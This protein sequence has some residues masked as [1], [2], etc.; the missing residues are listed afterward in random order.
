MSCLESFVLQYTL[1][2]SI[3]AIGGD[4]GLEDDAEGA[5]SNNLALG[6]LHLSSLAG[7]T[8]LNLFADDL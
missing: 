6:V 2:S 4:L 1:D 5:I 8:I 7:D 3:L